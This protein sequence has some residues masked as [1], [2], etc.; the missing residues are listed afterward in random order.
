MGGGEEERKRRR[1]GGESSRVFVKSSQVVV[2][3][4]S[5]GCGG[6]GLCLW[7]GEWYCGRGVHDVRTSC[8][9]GC[10]VTV[11]WRVVVSIPVLSV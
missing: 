9:S 8:K 3:C 4:S 5:G 11:K 6:Q 2:W 10:F 1:R 7:L